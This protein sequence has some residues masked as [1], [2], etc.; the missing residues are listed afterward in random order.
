MSKRCSKWLTVVAAGALA[1]SALAQ[2]QDNQDRSATGRRTTTT[3]TG[4]SGGGSSGRSGPAITPTPPADQRAPLPRDRPAPPPPPRSTAQDDR[5]S[6]DRARGGEQEARDRTRGSTPR[7]DRDGRRDDRY[8]GPYPRRPYGYYDYWVYDR[9]R[10]YDDGYRGYDP[11]PPPADRGYD[12][13]ADP[14]EAADRE[15]AP[16][17]A[18]PPDELMGDD[19]E[20][21]AALRKALEGSAE[22]REATAELLRAWAEYARSADAVLQRLRPMQAYQRALAALRE[23]EAGVARVRDRKA[24]AV[25]LVSAAQTAMLARREVR[26]LEEKAVDADSTAR[27]AK[28]RVDDAVERRN[29][30]RDEVRQKLGEAAG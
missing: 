10:Y 19:E 21:P 13:A 1:A 12:R 29:R 25:N 27:Q 28:R 24:P 15:A 17:A 8:R 16:G 5:S 22:F 26:K 4:G 3:T 2:S 30:V 11:T 23:A 9:S 20:L 18:L 7:D 6:N 14:E